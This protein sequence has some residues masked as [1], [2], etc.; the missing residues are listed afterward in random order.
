MLN[1][2]SWCKFQGHQF[3]SRNFKWDPFG[4]KSH[5][6]TIISTRAGQNNDNL[7]DLMLSLTTQGWSRWCLATAY[8]RMCLHVYHTEDTKACLL[9]I[10]Y[11]GKVGDQLAWQFGTSNLE[12]RS[13]MRRLKSTYQLVTMTLS[14]W[15]L[16]SVDM[17]CW[18]GYDSKYSLKS[19]C[20]QLYA[21]IKEIL[22]SGFQTLIL[23]LLT[24]PGICTTAIMHPAGPA[25]GNSR[26]LPRCHH[27]GERT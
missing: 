10:A 13:T 4:V 20:W 8:G 17:G 1:T 15:P 18:V 26:C 16:C 27:T 24:K 14:Q 21:Q 9:M 6:A 12:R 5:D 19:M 11:Y 7:T 2:F 3:H 22:E 23:I 25:G